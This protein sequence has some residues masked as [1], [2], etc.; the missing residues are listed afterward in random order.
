MR[1]LL[2]SALVL[3]AAFP[4]FADETKGEVVAF[5]RFARIIVMKDKTVWQLAADTPAPVALKAGDVIRIMY[6]TL[7]EDGLDKIT[8]IEVV[9]KN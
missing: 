9:A 7:G 2:S 3:C 1:I 6:E 4:A 8:A 5:D